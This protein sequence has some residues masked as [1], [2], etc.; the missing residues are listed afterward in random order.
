MTFR[1]VVDEIGLYAIVRTDAHYDDTS[2]LI[3]VALTEDTLRTAGRR[4]YNLLGGVRRCQESFLSHIPVL[5]Q[6]FTKMVGIDK[7]G[8]AMP[9]LT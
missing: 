9:M 5:R 1:I 2:T 6:V 4:L 7:D 3:M 8:G